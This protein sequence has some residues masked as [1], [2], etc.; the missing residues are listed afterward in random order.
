MGRPPQGI[1]TR[2]GL[3]NDLLAEV[4]LSRKEL[5]DAVEVSVRTIHNVEH[6]RKRVNGDVLAR[7]AQVINRAYS[8]RY[9]GD[10]PLG[11]TSDFFVAADGERVA[12]CYVSSIGTGSP[13]L[14]FLGDAPIADP[15]IRYDM[16]GSD[17]GLTFAG[18]F[19]GLDIF[20][21]YES[22]GSSLKIE[23]IQSV[24]LLTHS[25]RQCVTVK[26]ETILGHHESP[27]TYLLTSYTELAV[28]D[29]RLVSSR[30]IYDSAE[31][32]AFLKNGISPQSRVG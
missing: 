2:K 8:Q 25:A 29:G 9:P 3:L 7:I 26:N 16:P 22:L 11:L 6:G 14:L 19:H 4:G 18:S 1:L 32:A 5:A 20:D 27:H 17:A 31:L 30:A 10:R 21:F 15:S 23:A 24:E 13:R 28:R 12:N